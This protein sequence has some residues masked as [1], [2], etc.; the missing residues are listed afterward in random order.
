[1]SHQPLPDSYYSGSRHNVAGFLPGAAA[2]VLEIGC[3][4]GGF[5]SHF[6]ETTEYWGVE[7]N[8]AAA[9]EAR[10]RLTKVI[11]GRIEDAWSALPEGH[12]D[13]VVCND[14]IEHLA[15]HDAFLQR[16]PQKLRAGGFLVGSIPNV[17]Y[18]ANLL[19][20][21]L[22][23]DWRYRDSGILDRTHL[24]FFT[25]KSLRRSFAEHGYAIEALHGI[26]PA[27]VAITDRRWAPI[28]LCG[29]V[30]GADTRYRQF[31]FRVRPPAR[32]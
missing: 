23:R 2:R 27:V 12:F 13:V 32:A 9:D 4:R 15:D 25:E 29:W 26:D 17:R 10:T 24:R 19:E 7:A 22:K 20:L 3:G 6:P 30:L 28:T 5:R 21:L 16:I 14:V 31:G 8:A 11:A 1:M 18:V